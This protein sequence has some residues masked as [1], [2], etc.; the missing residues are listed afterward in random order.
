MEEDID[1]SRLFTTKDR[2]KAAIDE[3]EE[4]QRYET[5]HNPENLKA[6]AVIHAF[7]KRK[8]RVC[9]GG[10]A[11][12]AILPP[13]KRF[14]SEELDLPDYDFF[15]PDVDSDIKDL[16]GDLI[17]AG[18]KEVYHKVGIHEGTKK[19]MVNF[20]P[21]ADITV[22]KPDLYEVY[23]K[24]AVVKEGIYYTD[25]DMLRAMMYLELSRPKG[26]VS[27]WEKVFERLQLINDNFPMKR[28]KAPK[29]EPIPT[30]TSRA[31]YDFVIE[32]Q[33]VLCTAPI[34]VY[35]HGV[36]G[37]ALMRLKRSGPIGFASP[38]ARADATELKARIGGAI[39]LY[40]AVGD[41]PERYEIRHAGVTVATLFE[42]TACHAYYQVSTDDGR[43]ILIGSLEFLITLYLTLQIF[44]KATTPCVRTLIDLTRKNYTSTT[45]Q[46]P[47]ISVLCKGYQ[48]GFASL[49][50]KK[51]NR[52]KEGTRKKRTS[53]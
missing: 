43:I 33:R 32:N 21:V 38:N 42:D 36:K 50:R 48:I 14:Y 35:E 22:L 49:L 47:P 4:R 1:Y 46:F 28:C 15:T 26:M 9:Y 39:Y 31:I 8:G 34:G 18:F 44:T 53:K 24:R 19:I 7:I 20:M 25:P 45:S 13:E 29:V 5:A 11:M 51:V 30:E 37:S 2:I 3:A 23:H 6:L 40:K 10:T 12:N 41:A 27:R 16:L 52:I 17:K